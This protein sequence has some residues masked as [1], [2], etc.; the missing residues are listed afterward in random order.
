MI[1]L[2]LQQTAKY[3]T[4]HSWIYCSTRETGVKYLEAER[5][6]DSHHFTFSLVPSPHSAGWGLCHSSSKS[7]WLLVLSLKCGSFSTKV[8]IELLPVMSVKQTWPTMV[9]P[10]Q[11]KSTW[12]RSILQITLS[13]R[14]RGRVKL[15]VFTKSR[16]CSP[17]QSAVITSVCVSVCLLLNISLFTWLFVPQTILTFSAADEG[18]KF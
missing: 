2:R 16:I 4:I 8:E 15:Y 3:S 1:V 18:R 14:A 5:P 13:R 12:N 11:W 6:A 9:A 10:A 7:W 17:E